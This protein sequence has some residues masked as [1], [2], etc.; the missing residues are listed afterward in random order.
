MNK[1]SPK[2]RAALQGM[3]AAASAEFFSGCFHFRPAEASFFQKRA[4]C[5][6]SEAVGL[7]DND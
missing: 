1:K 2:V 6:F 5:A 4:F 7:F 3:A